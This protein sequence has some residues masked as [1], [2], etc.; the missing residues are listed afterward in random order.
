VVPVNR[1]DSSGSEWSVE[2][3][4]ARQI[5]ASK[6]D[7]FDSVAYDRGSYGRLGWTASGRIIYTSDEGGNV[8]IWSMNPDGSDRR[9]LTVDPHWDTAPALSPDGRRIAFMS[10]RAGTESL[11]VMDD[12]GGNQ[13]PLTDKFIERLPVF[14]GDSK[15]VFFNSW[16]T[17]IQTIWKKPIDGGEAVQV[18][19]GLSSNPIISP[20]GRLMAYRAGGKIRV[21]PA[22]GRGGRKF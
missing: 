4:G 9:Q 2:T 18:V 5:S 16:E 10:S 22:G 8:D 21:M 19:S 3:S 17:G 6:V 11:W 12:D 13:R 7:G 1:V 14:S 20:D 15:W